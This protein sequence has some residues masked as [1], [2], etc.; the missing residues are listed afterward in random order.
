MGQADICLHGQ[1]DTA[2][3]EKQPE[4]RF[5]IAFIICRD[6]FCIEVSLFYGR[7]FFCE[8]RRIRKGFC[9]FYALDTAFHH[10]LPQEGTIEEG[11]FQH[12]RE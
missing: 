6:L 12:L 3:I 4:G 11:T 8:K 10:Q 5:R 9:D 7:L 1:I 2:G